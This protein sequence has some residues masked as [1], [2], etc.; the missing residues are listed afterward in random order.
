MKRLETLE[1]ILERLRMS[2]KKKRTQKFKTEG[3][4]GERFVS[5]RHTPKP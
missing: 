4:S 3:R 2:I 5:Q 1:S